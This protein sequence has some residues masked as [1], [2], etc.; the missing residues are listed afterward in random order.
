MNIM[1]LDVH[2]RF[3]V[4]GFGCKF[5]LWVAV[6]AHALSGAVL[7]Q[8]SLPEMSRVSTATVHARVVGSSGLLRGADVYTNYKLEILDTWKSGASKLT[9][10]AVPGGTAGGIRQMVPGAPALRVGEEY[11]LF[12]WTG[13]SGLTQITGLS[14]GVFHV[15]S[16]STRSNEASKPEDLLVMRP[17]AHERMLDSRGRDVVSG[18]ETMKFFELR[19]QIVGAVRAGRL[20]T[21]QQ[22]AEGSAR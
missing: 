21:R 20:M 19:R 2:Q 5:G 10:V 17:T 11:V 22:L 12:L 3:I 14:Q 16:G 1:A 13:R 15:Q 8:L 4:P 7:L 6:A 9:T 18:P